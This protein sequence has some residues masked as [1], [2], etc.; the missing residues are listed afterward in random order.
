MT[1]I[2]FVS[3]KHSPGVTTS[4]AVIGLALS[5]HT[6]TALVELDSAGGDLAAYCGLNT[7]RGVLSSIGLLRD[8]EARSTEDHV[9]T[10][11]GL[12]VLVGP[13]SASQMR[14]ASDLVS[15][16]LLTATQSAFDVALVDLGRVTDQPA[17]QTITLLSRAKTI[18][19]VLR[20]SLA[21][22]EYVRALLPNLR[23]LARTL[24]LVV[25]TTPY[26]PTEVSRTLDCP[27]LGS[28]P[29]SER[30]VELVLDKPNSK[31][32]QRTALMRQARV[33]ATELLAQ[34]SEPPAEHLAAAG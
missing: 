6:P 15:D 14:S 12:D 16:A 13:M 18:V 3:A 4:A 10:F 5:E 11:G 9:Q 34:T 30:D 2:A 27:L 24:L 21:E 7:S 19:V 17:D 28:L 20:P 22:V 26:S 29:F 31:A 1:T 32:A 23:K 33:C 25:G 8:S